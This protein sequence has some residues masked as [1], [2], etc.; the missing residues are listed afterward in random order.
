MM[1]MAVTGQSFPFYDAP[2]ALTDW[3]KPISFEEIQEKYK[4]FFHLEKR[5]DGVV[6][7]RLHT[8]GGPLKFSLRWHH[9]QP[10]FYRDIGQDRTNEVIIFTG[11]GDE[12]TMTSDVAD[13]KGFDVY[14]NSLDHFWLD[15]FELIEG[16]LYNLNMPVITAFNGPAL[17]HSE[18]ALMADYVIASENATFQDAHFENNY[19]AGDGNSIVFA[20]RM[21]VGRGYALALMAEKFGAADALKYGLVNEVVPQDKLLDRAY[22]VADWLMSRPRAVR[23]N[24]HMVIQRHWRDVMHRHLGHHLGAEHTALYVDY[25]A[26][27]DAWSLETGAK[28][29]TGD[30]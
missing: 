3:V 9:A 20:E 19:V 8:Q 10:L 11:T 26:M 25:K 5:P 21:G 12:F 14:R 22:A 28:P 1:I 6:L 23:R 7:A 18:W 4:E 17:V 15:A 27:A 13:F 24:Q 30:A 29:G 16:F 2:G